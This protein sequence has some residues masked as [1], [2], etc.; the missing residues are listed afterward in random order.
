MQNLCLILGVPPTI[1]LTNVYCLPF[2]VI[3]FLTLSFVFYFIY[4]ESLKNWNFLF[5]YSLYEKYLTA[6][7]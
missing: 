4:E 1:S 7:A 3:T 5:I 6:S 2:I